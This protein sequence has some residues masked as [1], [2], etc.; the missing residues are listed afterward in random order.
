MNVRLKPVCEGPVPVLHALSN[1][2]RTLVLWRTAAGY[3][4]VRLFG[5]AYVCPDRP[6]PSRHQPAQSLS[7]AGSAL[8]GSGQQGAPMTVGIKV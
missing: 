4:L 7:K 1:Y 2:C 8:A 5:G 6:K 3:N